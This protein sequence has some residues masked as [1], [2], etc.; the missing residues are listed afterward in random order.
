MSPTRKEG[1]AAQVPRSDDWV[2]ARGNICAA[3]MTLP[4]VEPPYP[5][6]HAHSSEMPVWTIHPGDSISGRTKFL[7]G[8]TRHG[9]SEARRGQRGLGRCPLRPRS[10][11]LYDLGGAS[12]RTSRVPVPDLESP[13]VSESRRAV[14]SRNREPRELSGACRSGCDVHECRSKLPMLTMNGLGTRGCAG[15]DRGGS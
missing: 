1:A 2:R 12:R 7:E 8:Q 6:A 4:W 14:Q 13:G 5:L 11:P 9:S 10:M 3:R 15:A